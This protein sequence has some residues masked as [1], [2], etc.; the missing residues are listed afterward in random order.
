MSEP[1]PLSAEEL[2]TFLALH[3]PVATD[4][5][6]ACYQDAEVWPCLGWRVI[7]EHAAQATEIAALRGALEREKRSEWREGLVAVIDHEG[8]YLG[9]MGTMTWAVLAGNAGAVEFSLV[10]RGGQG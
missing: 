10:R 1:T 5:G 8:N 7:G 6:F 4:D 2:N 3:S 9:C